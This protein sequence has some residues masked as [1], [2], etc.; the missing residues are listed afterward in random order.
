MH[1]NSSVPVKSS[2][3]GKYRNSRQNWETFFFRD[4]RADPATLSGLIEN[5]YEFS[6]MDSPGCLVDVGACIGMSSLVFSHFNPE[7][8]I[9][10][11]EPMPESA[12]VIGYNCPKAKVRTNWIGRGQGKKRSLYAPD[13]QYGLNRRGGR[14]GKKTG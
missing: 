11:F 14:L 2:I 4:N 6:R 1:A 10:C 3:S 8:E 12:R 7:K 5:Q 13:K 9:F